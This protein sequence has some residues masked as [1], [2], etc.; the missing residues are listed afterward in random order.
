MTF[1][2]ATFEF[3]DTQQVTPPLPAPR[4]PEEVRCL[5]AQSQPQ[6]ECSVEAL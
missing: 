3:K 2:E 4:P 6:S 5:L 1:L